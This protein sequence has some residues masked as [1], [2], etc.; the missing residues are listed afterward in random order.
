M[1]NE[2]NSLA[3][4]EGCCEVREPA[5]ILNRPICSH[6][7]FTEAWCSPSLSRTNASSH[8]PDRL[9]LYKDTPELCFHRSSRLALSARA[10]CFILFVFP[11]LFFVFFAV[12]FFIFFFFFTRGSCYV[13]KTGSDHVIFLPHPPSTGI[14]H[15]HWHAHTLMYT[16]SNTH[17]L[18]WGERKERYRVCV[19]L[20]NYSWAWDSIGKRDFPLAIV[21][22]L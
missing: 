20:T 4:S 1:Q 3:L 11:L 21:C 7:Y 5:L 17:T 13:C 10:F 6:L 9:S 2:Q 14:I 16:C 15:M 18:S 22:P 8:T 12:L 19:V